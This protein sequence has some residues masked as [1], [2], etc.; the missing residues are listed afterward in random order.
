MSLMVYW[1]FVFNFKVKTLFGGQP[2]QIP[3]SNPPGVA[4]WYYGTLI[5]LANIHHSVVLTLLAP[6]VASLVEVR[7]GG[8][9][10]LFETVK[11]KEQ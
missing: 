10:S 11:T 2:G 1:P 9:S 7:E 5:L 4:R 6:R 3:S 8:I